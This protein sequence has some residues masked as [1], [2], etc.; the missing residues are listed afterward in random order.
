MALRILMVLLMLLP[1]I[2]VQASSPPPTPVLAS[3]HP[4][5]GRIWH[6]ESGHFLTSEALEALFGAAQVVVLG[7]THDNPD[8]HAVQAWAVRAL[9]AA[10]AHPRIAFEMI[11]RDRQ[12]DLES[13]VGD[14]DQLGDALS[15]KER[16]WPDWRLYRPIAEAALDGGGTL[17]AANLPAD[18]TRQ[19]ARRVEPAEL[20]ERLGLDIPLPDEIA[21]ALVEEI[22]SS[23]CNMMPESAIPAMV[24]VQRAR[25]A[26]MAD[27]VAALAQSAGPV[28]L[29]AGAGHAR[30][31]RGVPERLRQIAPGLRVFSLGLIEA[32]DAMTDPAAYAA[33]FDAVWFTGRAER[34]DPCA[35]LMRHMKKKAENGGK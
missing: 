20:A 32:D 26:E 19:I 23:H 21:A 11:D 3:N 4:L 25:D 30:T 9:V 18:A 12:G 10:G 6:P 8:H 2:S 13:N 17:S 16:G 28:V 27:T 24:R 7:E 5:A 1:A 22:R 15:W 34:E 31:D 14:L 29:I 35:Q 33:P